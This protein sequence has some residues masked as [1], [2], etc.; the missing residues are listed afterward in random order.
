MLLIS[1]FLLVSEPVTASASG[2]MPF[3]NFS[4]VPG[5]AVQVGARYD[6]GAAYR[7]ATLVAVGQT[8]P[9][10]VSTEP[11]SYEPQRFVLH[12]I[13]KGKAGKS[14]VSLAARVCHGTACSGIFLRN[15]REFLVLLGGGPDLY[16]KVDGDGNDPCPNFFEITADEALIG[17]IKIKVSA[18]KAFF[19]SKPETI[20]Y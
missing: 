11:F 6:I 19:E 18:L 3:C 17:K 8:E 7:A 4:T 13:L 2:M 12:R 20:A 1:I 9:A 14:L 15:D 16:G 5:H 10:K